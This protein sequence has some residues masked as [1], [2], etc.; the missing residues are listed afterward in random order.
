MRLVEDV[1]VGV[2]KVLHERFTP[3]KFNGGIHP[4][5][6]GE[7]SDSKI[8]KKPEKS[9]VLLGGQEPQPTEGEE[10][11][12][13]RKIQTIPRMSYD[14]AMAKFGSDKPDLRINRSH[15]SFVSWSYILTSFLTLLYIYVHAHIY[16]CVCV[17][18]NLRLTFLT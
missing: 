14:Y 2:F 11:P 18:V 8:A 3:V 5:Y 4:V 1:M 10:K 17:C 9:K 6:N 15:V 7:G 16:I 12:R 13:Y